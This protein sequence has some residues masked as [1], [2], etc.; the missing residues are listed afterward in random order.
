MIFDEIMN[1]N[2]AAALCRAEQASIA[3]AV[4]S[5]CF[6]LTPSSSF[7]SSPMKVHLSIHSSFFILA[8]QKI[9]EEIL[10]V[11]GTH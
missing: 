5:R 9:L 6:H 1:L 7:L 11:F 8:Q 2:M 3:L 10:A 4:T